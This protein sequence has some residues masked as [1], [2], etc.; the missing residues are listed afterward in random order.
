LSARG[1]LAV[2]LVAASPVIA[3]DP[4]VLLREPYL[5]LGTPESAVI[6]WRTDVPTDAWVAWGPRPDSLVAAVVTNDVGTEHLVQL[7]GLSP[8]TRYYYAVGS[9]QGILAGLDSTHTFRTA[10]VP[11][12]RERVRVWVIGDSGT[13]DVGA[14]RVRDAYLAVLGTVELD[15]WLMLGD[16]AYESGRGWQYDNAVF[17]MYPGILRRTFVWPTRGNHDDL[18][19][20]PNN[21]YYDFFTLPTHGEAGGVPSGTE[22]YYSF[23]RG[24]V[25]F[26]C[27]DSQGSDRTPGSA[28][29]SWLEQDLAA[30]ARDWTIAYWHHPPYTKGNHDSDSRSDSDGRLFDMRENAL[31]ILEDGGVDLVLTGHS[32]SYERSFLIDGHYGRSH[33][34]EPWMILDDSDGHPADDGAYRKATLGPGAHE[35]AVYAVVGSSGKVSQSGSLDHPVMVRS[36]RDLGSMFLLIDGSQL[37]AIWLDDDGEVRD[38]FR[39]VK[40]VRTGIAD[41]YEEGPALAAPQPNPFS[42]GTSFRFTVARAGT[43]RLSIFDVAGRRVAMLVDRSLEAGAHRVEWSGTAASGDPAAPGVYFAVLETEGVLRTK[44]VVRTR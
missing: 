15:V 17:R 5:Q 25:H 39:I 20:G 2:V 32:H 14:R 43:V 9:S 8:A 36:V 16:N 4:P 6:R 42:G 29:L 3:S 27:L 28:M 21:D 40:E 41:R 37:D 35:G 13:A 34:L 44:K 23:D 1:P 31:P 30:N 26:V 7:D 10:P 22:A 11:G 19:A 38:T 18:R 33:Q 24:N 12:T